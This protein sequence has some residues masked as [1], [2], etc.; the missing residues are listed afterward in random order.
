MENINTYLLIIAILLAFYCAIMVYFKFKQAK[1][2]PVESGIPAVEQPEQPIITRPEENVYQ[3][4]DTRMQYPLLPPV[5]PIVRN[6]QIINTLPV[7]NDM[8]SS[9]EYDTNYH[10]LNTPPKPG[11]NQLNFS[12]PTQLIKIPLHYNEP[13]GEQL[14]S[15]DILITPY[16]KIKYGSC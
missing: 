8:Y 14:R 4:E 16:N 1:F 6:R 11:V 3:T 2:S 15:Q 13:Y 12:E 5:N 10:I 7:S 9:Q